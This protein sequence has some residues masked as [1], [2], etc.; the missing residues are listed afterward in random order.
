M[1][2]RQILVEKGYTSGRKYGIIWIMKRLI[3]GLVLV[4]MV[5]GG[6][7]ADFVVSD[8]GANNDGI[9]IEMTENVLVRNCEIVNAHTVLGIGSG[10]SRGAKNMELIEKK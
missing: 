10:I 9:D 6:F 8:F 5:A 3:V 4:G 2:A 1:G 7:A